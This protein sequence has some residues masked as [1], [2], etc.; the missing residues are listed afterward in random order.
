MPFCLLIKAPLKPQTH[1]NPIKP[2]NPKAPEV[3]FVQQSLQTAVQK[4]D[5]HEILLFEDS[6]GICLD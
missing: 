2:S 1:Q 5:L 4:N 3:L 6:L